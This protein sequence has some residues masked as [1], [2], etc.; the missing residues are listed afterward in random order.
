[1]LKSR[2]REQTTTH[3]ERGQPSEAVRD[4]A[5]RFFA[6]RRS[7]KNKTPT[8]LQ[9]RMIDEGPVFTPPLKPSQSKR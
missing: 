6:Q 4:L 3:E 9:K 7:D 2:T 5:R 1:M 8:A